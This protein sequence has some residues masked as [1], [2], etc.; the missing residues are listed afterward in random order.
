LGIQI[1]TTNHQD[2]Q[3]LIKNLR[4]DYH[5]SLP[6]GSLWVN[7]EISQT[8]KPKLPY[9]LNDINPDLKIG[10]LSRNDTHFKEKIKILHNHYEFQRVPED[11]FINPKIDLPEDPIEINKVLKKKSLMTFKFP[12]IDNDAL[13]SIIFQLHQTFSFFRLPDSLIIKETLPEPEFDLIP[14]LG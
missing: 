11:W 2:T 10:Q 9:R 13:P 4:S 7:P 3:L 5:F 1:P 8:N 12:L 14:L 6:L